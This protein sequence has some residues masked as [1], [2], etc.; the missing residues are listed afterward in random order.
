MKRLK[1]QSVTKDKRFYIAVGCVLVVILAAG[2]V[3]LN[4]GGSVDLGAIPKAKVKA[5]SQQAQ[6]ALT[7]PEPGTAMPLPADAVFA[8]TG[9]GGDQWVESK[10]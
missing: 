8:P 5:M 1:D 3:M 7:P 9:N 6:P 4:R 10:K 2:S